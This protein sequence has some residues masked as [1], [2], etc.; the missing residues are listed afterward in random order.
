MK[1]KK[2]KCNITCTDNRREEEIKMRGKRKQNE[3]RKIILNV[4]IFVA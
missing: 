3:G 2:N 1:Q 4:H